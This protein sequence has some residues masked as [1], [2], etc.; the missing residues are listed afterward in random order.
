MPKLCS[1]PLID[2]VF[3]E[4]LKRAHFSDVHMETCA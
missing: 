3:M 4:N 2:P 1:L